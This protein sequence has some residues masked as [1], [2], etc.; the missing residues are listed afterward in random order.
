MKTVYDEALSDI[1]KLREVAEAN[2]KNTIIDSLAPKLKDLI[3][4]NLSESVTDQSDEDE[5]AV[6]ESDFATASAAVSHPEMSGQ[7]TGEKETT[8]EEK[9]N[10]TYEVKEES[11]DPLFQLSNIAGPALADRIVA[12]VY[13]TYDL[14]NEVITGVRSVE[15][16]DLNNTIHKIEDIYSY[17]QENN[18]S[19]KSK[20]EE[21]LE[22][23]YGLL[24]SFRESKMKMKELVSE[25]RTVSNNQLDEEKDV[26]LRIAGLPDDVELE[27]LNID[28]ISDEEPASEETEMSVSAPE[29]A[30]ASPEASKM[31][32]AA[33][34]E[35]D[36]ED[37]DEASSEDEDKASKDKKDDEDEVLM[38]ETV[39][40]VSV[41]MLREA[42]KSIKDAKYKKA[43]SKDVLNHFGGGSAEGDPL[44]DSDMDTMCESDEEDEDED[45]MEELQNRRKR[46]EKGR[47]QA[48]DHILPEANLDKM[49]NMASKDLRESKTWYL[50]Q[51]GTK[52]EANARKV[53]ERAAKRFEKVKTM[54]ESRRG[55]SKKVMEEAASL[56]RAAQTELKESRRENDDLRKQLAEVNLL[57]SKLIHANKLLQREGLTR[58]QKVTVIDRLDE[59]ASLREVKLIYES[60]IKAFEDDKGTV[61][62]GIA[63]RPKVSGSSSRVTASSDRPVVSEGVETARWLELAGLSTK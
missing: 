26:T 12:E 1:K 60:L 61:K 23:C 42:I 19:N 51:V 10:E 63:R 5:D 52:N 9:S 50:K 21:K 40:E 47:E 22:I 33:G 35:D 28:I 31:G 59:A 32:E 39:V 2:A 25:E 54:V 15:I 29:T 18:V 56:N 58:N 53:V 36:D 37:M 49:L 43:A 30:E 41:P 3:E 7:T 34:Y 57:N 17:L 16:Q 20:L 46:D 38:D 48:D 45:E 6:D 24:N 13:K 62:E 8:T 14:V 4:K 44:L 27:N 55:S 11:F